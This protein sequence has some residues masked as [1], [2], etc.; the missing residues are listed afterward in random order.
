MP[1]SS[2]DAIEKRDRR[3][4]ELRAA[5]KSL[6][7]I[8]HTLSLEFWPVTYERVGQKLRQLGVAEFISN[9]RL[10]G[11][12]VC[13]NCGKEFK[14][15]YKQIP[16]RVFCSRPCYM[17]KHTLSPLQRGLSRQKRLEYMRS[18]SRHRSSR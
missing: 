7:E 8:A 3:L 12:F 4:L 17:A 5:S 11:L 6:Q 15:K 13:A 10:A 2:K 18:Y 16:K 9:S 14:R 1:Y